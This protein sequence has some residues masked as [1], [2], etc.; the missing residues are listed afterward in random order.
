MKPWH[1]ET[2][3]YL[4]SV[5][6]AESSNPLLSIE[7]FCLFLNFMNCDHISIVAKKIMPLHWNVKC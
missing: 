4:S 7:L 2:I 5:N 6:M 3:A 1:A